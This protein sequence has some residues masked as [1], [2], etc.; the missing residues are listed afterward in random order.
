MKPNTTSQEQKAI[1]ALIY[2]CFIIEMNGVIKNKAISNALNFRLKL[3]DS[4]ILA[5]AQINDIPLLTADPEFKKVA[6]DAH[7]V[8]IF[9]Q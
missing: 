4:I 5:A 6:K 1:Q 9:E 3:A 2:E 7:K 8:L